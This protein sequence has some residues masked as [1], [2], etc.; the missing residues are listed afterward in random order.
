MAPDISFFGFDLSAEDVVGSRTYGS[1]R[2]AG[3]GY[4]IVIQE[5]PTEPRF[6]F[7]VG[8]PLGT[9]THLRV[10]AGAPA[11]VPLNGLEWGRNSSHMAGI[12]RQQP[13]RIAI[14]ASQL[15]ASTWSPA[16]GGSLLTNDSIS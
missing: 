1:G 6:G 16:I 15:V 7:D 13:V 11:G 3:P 4:Y 5:Q 14:H 8:T 2:V 9:G 10:S 12:V